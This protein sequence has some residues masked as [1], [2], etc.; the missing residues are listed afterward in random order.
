MWP[1]FAVIGC[2]EH[3]N[4]AAGVCRSDKG[5][6]LRVGSA[7]HGLVESTLDGASGADLTDGGAW[8]RLSSSDRALIGFAVDDD[9]TNDTVGFSEREKHEGNKE[10]D[11]REEESGGLH[12]VID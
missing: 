5:S 1:V 2:P 9:I 3:V 8:D 11:G 12:C 7:G 6:K 4:L 10:G